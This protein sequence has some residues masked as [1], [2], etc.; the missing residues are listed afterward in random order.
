MRTRPSQK[1][2]TRWCS[3]WL[4]SHTTKRLPTSQCMI[5]VAKLYSS[6]VY[7]NCSEKKFLDVQTFFTRKREKSVPFCSTATAA[8]VEMLHGLLQKSKVSSFWLINSSIHAGKTRGVGY[9]QYKNPSLITCYISGR[10]CSVHTRVM[11]TAW[12]REHTVIAPKNPIRYP[13]SHH[14]SVAAFKALVWLTRARVYTNAR[15][16]ENS[17]KSHT[18]TSSK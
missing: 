8:S 9:F 14:I 13:I 12:P 3:C 18:K 17:C 2:D 10:S 6:R 15:A 16:L 7:L 4:I 1:L 5:P 11:G